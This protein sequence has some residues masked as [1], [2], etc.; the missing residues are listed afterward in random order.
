MLRRK[1]LKA[2]CY[3]ME[4]MLFALLHYLQEGMHHTNSMVRG[5][6]PTFGWL[7]LKNK[8]TELEHIVFSW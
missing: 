4:L 5:I 1:Y 3:G 2:V 6:M 8:Q 7:I